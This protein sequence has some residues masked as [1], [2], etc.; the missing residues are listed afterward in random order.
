MAGLSTAIKTT[1]GPEIASYRRRGSLKGGRSLP[2]AIRAMEAEI[3]LLHHLAEL[4]E[5]VW[6]SATPGCKIP[7]R[8]DEA[9]ELV[10]RIFFDERVSEE[11]RSTARTAT[12]QTNPN[13]EVVKAQETL[14]TA[15]I[16]PAGF[17]QAICGSGDAAET[18]G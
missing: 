18:K 6:I 8:Q 17:K 7:L 12:K 9:T 13:E 5:G 15:V 16:Y 2:D 10:Y 3:D 1:A 11:V 14:E 4:T